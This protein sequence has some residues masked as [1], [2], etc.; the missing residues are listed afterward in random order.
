[1]S[2]AVK[3]RAVGRAGLSPGTFAPPWAQQYGQLIGQRRGRLLHLLEGG[4]LEAGRLQSVR[5][6]KLQ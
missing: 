3:F 1:M 5:S 4:L 2:R 6:R